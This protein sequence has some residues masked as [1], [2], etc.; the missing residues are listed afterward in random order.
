MECGTTEW[1][2]GKQKTQKSKANIKILATNVYD[3]LAY[4]WYTTTYTH[5][6]ESTLYIINSVH[7]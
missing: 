5:S 2:D 3:I 1:M 4:K 7:M 6:I